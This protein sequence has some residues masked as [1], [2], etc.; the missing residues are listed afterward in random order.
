[1][2]AAVTLLSAAAQ[3]Q[4]PTQSTTGT[5]SLPEAPAPQSTTAEIVPAPAPGTYQTKRILGVIPN[6]RSVSADAKL[7]PQSDKDKL[8]TGIQD[9]FDYSSFLFAGAQAGVSD[10]TR[11]TPQFG[12]GGVAYGRY[13]WHT[14]LDQADENLW[15]ESLIPVVTHEDSRYYTLG[16]GG[17]LKRTA[18][19]IS[20]AVITRTDSGHTTANISEVVGA[21]AAAGISGLYYPSA[22][23]TLTKT[24]QR[25]ITSLVIDG[26]TFVTKEF[27]PDLNRSI[28][29]QSAD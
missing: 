7:P 1:M 12:H 9:S 22:D 19:S 24:Y 4:S 25:W 15:V 14:F 17:L 21:G 26:A 11:A 28:F 8:L 2:L 16:H 3:Q 10:A 23:R 27:W 18:Y 20:R 13:Y 29:H 5:P 6:F